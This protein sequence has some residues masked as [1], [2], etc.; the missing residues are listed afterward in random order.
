MPVQAQLTDEQRKQLLNSVA[1]VT[2]ALR[3][4]AEALVPAVQAMG[5]EFTQ[6]VNALQAAGYLDED[7]KPIEHPDRPAWQSPYGPAPRRR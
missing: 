1:N 2:A 4:F 5:Q 7:G 3:A 6:L